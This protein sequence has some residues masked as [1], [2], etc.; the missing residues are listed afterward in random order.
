MGVAVFPMFTIELEFVL[1]LFR[2]ARIC[3]NHFKEEDYER[4]LRNELLNLPQR[5][6][7]K[8]STNFCQNGDL[9]TAT[10]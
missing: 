3:S 8:V 6:L 7:L 2:T 10:L 4:D 1:D 9:N 5:K